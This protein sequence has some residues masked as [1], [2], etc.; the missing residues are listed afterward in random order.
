MCSDIRIYYEKEKITLKTVGKF[1]DQFILRY[2]YG[3][4]FPKRI[5]V[6]SMKRKSYN[7]IT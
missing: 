2:Y 1:S 3:Y 6:I 4:F 7:M 5:N